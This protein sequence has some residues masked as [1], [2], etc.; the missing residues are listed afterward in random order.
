M[1][2]ALCDFRVL[3]SEAPARKIAELASVLLRCAVQINRNFMTRF[4]EK[5]SISAKNYE[6]AY[7]AGGV[8]PQPL[9]KREIS[10]EAIAMAKSYAAKFG[11]L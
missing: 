3:A 7:F 2:A 4:K 8:I 11:E 1:A 6:N 9:D 10:R 5:Q